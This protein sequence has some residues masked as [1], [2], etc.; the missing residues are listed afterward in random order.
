MASDSWPSSTHTSV[1]TVEHEQLV[2]PTTMDGLIGT[3]AD[4]AMVYADGTGRQVKLRANRGGIVR[5]ARYSS[6][7]EE[8]VISIA[9]NSSGSTRTDLVVLRLTRSTGVV[10]AYVITG[11]PGAGAPAPVR[12]ESTTGYY[13]LPLAAVTVVN[14]A[15]SVS[16][17]QCVEVA[18]YL[19]E[20]AI[21][22]RSSTRPPHAP[23]LLIQEYDTGHAYLSVMTSGGSTWVI[24]HRDSGAIALPNA[25]GWLG[26]TMEYRRQGNLVLVTL[27]AYRSGADLP[28]GSADSLIGTMP[29]DF[30]FSSPAE[31]RIPGAC[32]AGSVVVNTIARAYPNGQIKLTDQAATVPSGRFIFFPPIPWF[33]G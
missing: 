1:S 32:W 8:L 14:G 30:R 15:T 16:G 12:T 26:S 4:P 7:S 2:A 10:A 11:T 28:A 31:I 33:V 22:C 9:A 29:S 13:D 21:A 25:G 5:G 6:G 24:Q 27:T 3:P 23:G 17:A 20:G 19:S 18:W